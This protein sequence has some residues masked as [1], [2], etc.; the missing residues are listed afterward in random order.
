MK[1]MILLTIL[2]VTCVTHSEALECYSHSVCSQNCLQLTNTITSCTGDDN[3]CYKVAFPGGVIRGCAKEQCAIQVDAHSILASVCCENDLCN[4]AITSKLTFST[5]FM[6]MESTPKQLP[7][8]YGYLSHPLLPLQKA[9][10]PIAIQINQLDRYSKIA[11][12]ECRFPSDHDL[13]RDG[14]AAIYLYTIEWDIA[15]NFKKGDEFTWRTISSCAISVNIIKDFVG[16]N[17]TLFLIE[18]VNGKTI[19]RYTNFPSK[20][21]VIL[22]PGTRFRVVSDPLDEATMHVVH[23]VEITDETGDQIASSFDRTSAMPASNNA[24]VQTATTIESSEVK[25]LTD[26]WGNRYE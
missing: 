25:T 17:S 4:L 12:N 21:E 10:E 13:T 8:I 1:S 19:S 20:N 15:K 22:C 16:P 3:R 6:I 18:A 7:P 2:L 11:E 5:L 14:S 26:Q 24:S 9:L 23:L